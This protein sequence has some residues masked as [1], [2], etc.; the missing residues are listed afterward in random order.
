MYEIAAR[1]DHKLTRVPE[2][3][4][5]VVVAVRVPMGCSAGRC[6]PYMFVVVAAPANLTGLKPVVCLLLLLLHLTATSGFVLPS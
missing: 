2:I 6:G 5:A 3:S 4:L 1:T